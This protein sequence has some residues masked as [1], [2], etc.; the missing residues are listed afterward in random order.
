MRAR[1]VR[2]VRPDILTALEYVALAGPADGRASLQAYAESLAKARMPVEEPAISTLIYRLRRD[3]L[4]TSYYDKGVRIH[5]VTDK[6][7]KAIEK[8]KNF[9][10][11]CS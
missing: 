3:G 7:R 1:K 10:C 4:I 5:E 6:G 9:Y 2:G 8:T 11:R